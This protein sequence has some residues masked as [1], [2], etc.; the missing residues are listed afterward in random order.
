[1]AVTVTIRARLKAD[2]DSGRSYYQLSGTDLALPIEVA[3]RPD[4][5]AL[6]WHREHRF[7]G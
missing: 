2:F 7:L 6:A 3:R 1:M 5:G 4:A